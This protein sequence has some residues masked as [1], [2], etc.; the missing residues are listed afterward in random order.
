MSEAKQPI[1][2]FW[3]CLHDKVFARQFW[4]QIE[5]PMILAQFAKLD[6]PA[7]WQ[8][9]EPAKKKAVSIPVLHWG[10]AK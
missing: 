5:R 10:R 2:P 6:D 8:V 1:D 9:N 4:E 7:F 3:W